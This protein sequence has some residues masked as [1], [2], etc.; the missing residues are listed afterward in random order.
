MATQTS[1]IWS[2]DPDRTE[3]TTKRSI[4]RGRIVKHLLHAIFTGEL[5][6]GDRLVEED[7]AERLGVSRTPVREALRELTCTGII[8]LRPNH[9]AT[10]RP[11]GPQQLMEV[12]QIRRLL[13]VEATRQCARFI[14][15]SALRQIRQEMEALAAVDESKHGKEWSDQALSLDQRLHELIA[16]SSGSERLSEEIHRYWT[17]ARSIGE[18]VK[19][20]SQTQDHALHEHVKIIDRL[21]DRQSDEAAAAMGQHIDRRAKAA[22]TAL[23][24][25]AE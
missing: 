19:N 3:S 14:S 4:P 17:L 11:F 20:K 12:Y 8:F 5:V 6:G 23:F 2:T 22:L 18:A 16:C 13:E 25:Q 15:P 24:P 10:V 21:I 9:G 1:V 7:I